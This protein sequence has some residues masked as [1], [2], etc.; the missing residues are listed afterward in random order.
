MH[1]EIKTMVYEPK[2][3]IAPGETL[4]EV[5]ESRDMKQ[6]ELARRLNRPV[7]TI[8]EIIKGKAAI[9]PETALQLERVFSISASFWNNLESNYQDL[10]IRI[11]ETD[12]LI[13]E[14][15]DIAGE[16]PY[17]EMVKYGW[18]PKTEDAG[19]RI[20]N[21]LN[22]FGVIS[23]KLVPEKSL[24]RT[25]FRPSRERNFSRQGLLAWLRKG[26]NDASQIEVKDFDKKKCRASIDDMRALTVEDVEEFLPK[27]ESLLSD[28]G[29]VLVTTPHLKNVPIHGATRWL[30]PGKAFIQMSFRFKSCDIFWF[31]FFHELAHILFHSKKEVHVDLYGVQQNTSQEVQADEFAA[32]HLIPQ[33]NYSEFVELDDFSSNSVC[34]FAN[35]IDIHPGIVVGRL[36]FDRLLQ[37]NQLNSLKARVRWVG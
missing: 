22:F 6:T 36:Q 4:L 8:N 26:V 23:L 16:Y 13:K 30:T 1:D 19:V 2:V 12:R 32:N 17:D 18:I 31:S 3:V 25:N 5:L 10:K 14:E 33:S 24:I 11:G 37:F 15:L 7:K 28:C 29:I 27:L 20:R 34:E 9:T 35:S 21:L